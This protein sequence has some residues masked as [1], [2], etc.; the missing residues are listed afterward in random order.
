MEVKTLS[1]T[2]TTCSYTPSPALNLV[3]GQY[4]WKVRAYN[5]Y[6]GPYGAYMSFTKK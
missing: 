2:A 5:G 6:Y 4:K 1:C 3:N